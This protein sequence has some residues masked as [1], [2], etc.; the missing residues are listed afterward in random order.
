MRPI[1]F[2]SIHAAAMLLA[3]VI[4][5]LPAQARADDWVKLNNSAEYRK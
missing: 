4:L 5:V 2:R 3:A 1:R